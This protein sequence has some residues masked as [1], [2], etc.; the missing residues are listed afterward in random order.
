M[1]RR[2]LP[3]RF[4]GDGDWDEFKFQFERAAKINKWSEDDKSAYLG[5]CLTGNALKTFRALDANV[6]DD[7]D[8]A[9]IALEAKFQPK[10][11]REAFLIQFETRE[12][13][14]SEELNN[15]ATDLELLVRKA[16][17]GLPNDALDDLVRGRFLACLDPSIRLACRQARPKT[18][19]EAVGVAYEIEGINSRERIL[20]TKKT[21]SCVSNKTECEVPVC[22]SVKGLREDPMTELL[23][24]NATAMQKMTEALQELRVN[25]PG[26][27]NQKSQRQRQRVCYGCGKPG[28]FRSQCPNGEAGNSRQPNSGNGWRL[29]PE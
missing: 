8:L 17:P 27:E 2:V 11:K 24:A 6:Q 3:E 10:E 13:G 29:A 1:S 14:Q 4:A 9:V 19:Q 23:R 7:Y 16:Y 5:L 18:L 21:C 12:R 20:T 15:L 28:H 25:S 22:S 26:N